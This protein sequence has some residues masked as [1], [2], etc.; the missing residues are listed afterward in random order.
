MGDGGIG[1]QD[2]FICVFKGAA[3]DILQPSS[4]CSAK[5]VSAPFNLDDG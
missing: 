1:T 2:I 5:E 3:V 4:F